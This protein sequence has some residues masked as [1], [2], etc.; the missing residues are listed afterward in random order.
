MSGGLYFRPSFWA[1]S[2]KALRTSSATLRMPV[3]FCRPAISRQSSSFQRILLV[4]GLACDI[5]LVSFMPNTI[6][7]RPA[8]CATL[9]Y[10]DLL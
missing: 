1:Q 10:I 8:F 9:C 2:R 4:C 7:H 3:F 6:A 5:T